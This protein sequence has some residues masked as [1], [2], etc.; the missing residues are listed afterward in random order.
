MTTQL[1]LLGASRPLG[2]SMEGDERPIARHTPAQ[3]KLRLTSLE[4][5]DGA[6]SSTLAVW[7]TESPACRQQTMS[8]HS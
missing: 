6:R 3:Q 4:I 1:E 8:F 5:V 2:G 7:R